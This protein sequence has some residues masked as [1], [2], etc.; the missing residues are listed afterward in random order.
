MIT[1]VTPTFINLFLINTALAKYP[2][3]VDNSYLQF[4]PP[5]QHSEAFYAILG[6][7]WNLFQ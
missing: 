7:H 1:T 6:F 3:Y 2:G 4:Q 5:C